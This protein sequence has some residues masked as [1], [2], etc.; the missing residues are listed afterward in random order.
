MF[1]SFAGVALF[2]A[3]KAAGGFGSAGVGDLLC[4]AA[5]GCFAAYAVVNRPLLVR[6]SASRVTGWALTFGS[7]PVLFVTAPAVSRQDWTVVTTVGWL[8]LLWAAVVPTYVC[9]T[10]WSWVNHRNGVGRS[11]MFLFLV[12]LVSGL[13]SW[14]LLDEGFGVL[15]IAGAALTLAGL[16]LAHGAVRPRRM[17]WDWSPISSRR[18]VAIASARWRRRSCDSC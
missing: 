14:L 9:W 1:V 16:M 10:L 5:A 12:P 4:L 18:S 15:K 8:L 13:T 7:I 6:Y 3:D 17:A 2:L 11:A